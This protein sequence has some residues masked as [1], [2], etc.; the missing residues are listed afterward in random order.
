M[1]FALAF[2]TAAHTMLFGVSRISLVGPLTVDTF[3][4]AVGSDLWCF[5][6]M[7]LWRLGLGEVPSV[8]RD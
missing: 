8:R 5:T 4:A 1:A 7:G 2:L 6:D 3:L